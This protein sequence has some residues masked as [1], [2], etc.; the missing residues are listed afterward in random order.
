[1]SAFIHDDFLLETDTARDLYHRV[2]KDLPI[3]DYHCHLSPEA[4]AADHR[5]RSI[6]EIWL[7]GDHYKWRAMRA[8][9]VPERFCSGDASD[10]EK[11]EAWAR[12][13]PA[14]LGNP[15]YHWTA[16]EL[17]R[18]FGIDE[19]LSPDTARTI[20]D[21]CN[22][23]LGGADF[24]ALGL[25]RQFRVAV[26]CTTDDPTDSL[27]AH[28]ALAARENPDTRVY[29]TWRPDKALAV[30]DVVSWNAWVEALE[31]ASL[32][33][34]GSWETFLQALEARHTVFHDLGCRASDHGLERLPDG[35]IGDSEAAA[36]F[37]RLR[38]GRLLEAE[39]ARVF[40]VTL[41]HVLALLDH[42]R[43]WVQQFHLGAMRNNNTR[44][45]RLLG[46]DTGYDSMGD[47]EQA[48]SLSRFLDRLDETDHLAK[49]ILYNLNPADNA[50]FATM[51]GNFQDGS[52]PGKMQWG[53]GWWFLD[54]LDGMEAQMRTLANM[55]LL[56]R[57]VGMVTDSRSFLSFPRHDYFRR[58]L[59]RILGEEVRRGHLPDDAEALGALVANVCFFN[60]R[61]Y[62]GFELGKAA[63]GR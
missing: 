23:K 25:L 58:L 41:L 44:M 20:F 16:M 60:A 53:S 40:R 12:T 37:E 7:D 15:L 21:Q 22:E 24:T 17:H 59:C 29:P 42:E 18:P 54:Q 36:A 38:T 33:P 19:P 51:V 14:T 1:M 13:V 43:G 45:H 39:Q 32:V 11:F 27:E 8:N 49:T 30:A 26:V 57:F 9:G 6:S 3:V 28:S 63:A 56:S 31:R 4:M 5:F 52:A 50:L 48:L 55:G 46:P 34:I 62:F 10:W 35:P 47:F 61:D 2:A